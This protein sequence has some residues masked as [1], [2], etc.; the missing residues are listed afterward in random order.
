[1]A[2]GFC[3]KVGWPLIGGKVEADRP[4]SCDLESDYRIQLYKAYVS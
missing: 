1:M 3:A 4:K 2:L